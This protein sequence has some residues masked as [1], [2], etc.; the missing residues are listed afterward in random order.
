MNATGIQTRI[1]GR[2]LLALPCILSLG[3]GHL[4]VAAATPQA[5]DW[6]NLSA[7]NLCVTEGAV[8]KASGERLSVNTTKMR[9]YVTR[10]TSQTVELRF[11]YLGGTSKESALGSGE[12][13]RQLGLKL[14][15]QDPCN[16]VYVMWRI[17]PESELVVSVK[18]NRNQHTSSE[19]SNHGY[20]NIKPARSSAIP[21]LKAGQTQTLRAELNG[22]ELTVYA[23]NREVWRGELGP[24]AKGLAGPIGIRSDNAHF[25]FD[26]KAH[27]SEGMHPD[28]ALSCKT[29]PANSD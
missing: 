1:L 20:E 17:E 13:R 6:V 9:A 14:R 2:V 19:C 21:K 8:D 28:S 5:N 18:R 16:L 15:A 10:E 27:E 26:L 4:S 25:E 24:D 12:I 7:S 23:D 29:G 3:C 11:T 22:E